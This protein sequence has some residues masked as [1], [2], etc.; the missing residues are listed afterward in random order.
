ML[1]YSIVRYGAFLLRLCFF[2]PTNCK[3]RGLCRAWHMKMERSMSRS[4]RKTPITGITTARSE[5]FDKQRWHRAY[6]HAERQR[7]H[8][9]PYSCP[10]HPFEVTSEGVAQHVS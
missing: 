5:K 8:A 6:R 10:R 1:E 9:N 3:V 2:K 4:R 7:L